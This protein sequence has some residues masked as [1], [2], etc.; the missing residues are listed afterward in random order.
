[1]AIITKYLGGFGED[2]VITTDYDDVTLRLTAIRCVN[3]TV[4]PVG[5][6]IRNIATGRERTG[7]FQSGT[8]QIDIPQ[9]P[10]QRMTITVDQYGR[11]DGMEY[12]LEYPAVN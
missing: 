2:V 10:S 6:W 11:I 1:M 8:T 5:W 4:L 12:R 7:Q 9:T 3:N